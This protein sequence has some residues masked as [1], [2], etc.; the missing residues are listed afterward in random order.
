MRIV[1]FVLLVWLVPALALAHQA[2]LRELGLPPDYSGGPTAPVVSGIG[3]AGGA[4][5]AGGRAPPRL[6]EMPVSTTELR[7]ALQRTRAE[8]EQCLVTAGL[9]GTLR[10]TARIT[11]THSL[12]LDIR[13]PRSEVPSRGCV[14]LALRRTLTQLAARPVDRTIRAS[15]SVRHVEP[16]VPRPPPHVDSGPFAAPVHEAIER[17]RLAMIQCLS[18]AAPGTTGE[19]TLHMTLAADGTLALTRVEMPS[20]VPAGSALPC[21]SS[22]IAQLRFAPAP[23]SAIDVAHTL[24]LGL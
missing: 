4:R 21:L 12:Q 16:R 13:T 23:P 6:D 1:P 24:P 8:L 20:G 17:D 11:T 3:S 7:D 22:R 15:L 18:S 2:P 14:D 5:V 10:V 9:T 19:A